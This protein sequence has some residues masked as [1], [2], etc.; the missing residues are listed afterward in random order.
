MD[1]YEL[2]SDF[3]KARF[4]NEYLFGTLFGIMWTEA[5]SSKKIIEFEHRAKNTSYYYICENDWQSRYLQNSKILGNPYASP[6]LGIMTIQLACLIENGRKKNL[7]DTKQEQRYVKQLNDYLDR[8]QKQTK[9]VKFKYLDTAGGT[10][11]F[12]FQVSGMYA[13][14]DEFTSLKEKEK[15]KLRSRL[16]ES[17]QYEQAK[18]SIKTKKNF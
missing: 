15:Q 14:I 3:A 13:F 17:L 1:E 4:E 6:E 5:L 10:N 18:F 11:N 9:T 16:F 2:Y 12:I 7:M 8:Y